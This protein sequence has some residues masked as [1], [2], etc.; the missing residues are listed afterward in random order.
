[1]AYIIAGKTQDGEN[2]IRVN[3]KLA[4]VGEKGDW[5]LAGERVGRRMSTYLDGLYKE[6]VE[7]SEG[8]AFSCRTKV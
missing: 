4:T 8:A 7:L 3:G 1:M 6:V 5:L 2:V